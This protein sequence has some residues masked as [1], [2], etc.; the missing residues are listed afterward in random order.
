MA[1]PGFAWLQPLHPHPAGSWKAEEPQHPLWSAHLGWSISLTGCSS[2]LEN[3]LLNTLSG[4]GVKGRPASFPFVPDRSQTIAFWPM[5]SKYML[6]VEDV[7][8]KVRFP[9][10]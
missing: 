1:T 9:G 7:L 5:S 3:H 8:M 4:G 10:W 2:L 6:W